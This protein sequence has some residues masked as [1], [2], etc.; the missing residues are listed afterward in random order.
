MKRSTCE[1][2]SFFFFFFMIVPHLHFFA[3]GIQ[4]AQLQQLLGH[5]LGFTEEDRRVR[6]VCS[7]VL[8]HFQQRA[9]AFP[10]QVAL[11]R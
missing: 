5:F 1:S 11:V 8:R 4:L 2:L 9:H 6:G 3:F 10:Q 7:V